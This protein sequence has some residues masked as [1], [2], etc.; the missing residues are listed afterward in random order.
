MWTRLRTWINDRWPV[1]AVVR[2]IREEEI[3]GGSRFAYVFGSVS[4]VLF[5][6]L[7][8][9]GVL[10]IFYYVPTVDHAYDSVMYLRL[11]V[12][13]GWLVHG[14]HYWCAQAFAVVVGLHMARVFLWGAYK[15]PREVTWLTGVL[16]L[17]LVAVM[18]FM[19]PLLAWDQLGF[20][21]A[22][23]GTSIVGTVPW[24]GDFLQ[25][26]VRG[27]E[28][29]GQ[30]TLSRFFVLHVAILPG[31]LLG[32]I[33]LHLV[34]FRQSGSVGPWDPEQRRTTGRFWPDQVYK[35]ILVTSFV[36]VILVGLCAF[37]RAPITGPAD[38]LGRSIEPK[39]VWNFLFLYQ[40][41]KLFKGPW[42]LVGTV[43]LPL[44][45]VLIL[46]LLPFYDRTP[47][48]NPRR[49]PVALAGATVF[50]LVIAVL[51]LLGYWAKPI[52]GGGSPV[53]PVT[54]PNQRGAAP[55][56]KAPPPGVQKGR[57]LFQSQ[58]CGACHRID[59]QSGS[60]GPDLSNEASAGKSAQWLA[61]QIRD[62]KAHNANSTMPSYSSL[63]QEQV[64]EL[65]DYLLTLGSGGA[66]T[67]TESP[68]S[69]EETQT[70]VQGR[71]SKRL[72]T[73][74]AQGPPG[75]AATLIGD[76]RLGKVLFPD[77][78]SSC[79]GPEGVDKVPNPGS[80]R[81]TVPALNPIDPNLVDKEPAAFA[82]RIDRFIQHGS[83]PKGPHPALDMPAYG[84]ERSLT[85]PQIAAV[86]A[87]ILRL[88]GVDRAEI[89]HPGMTP[90]WFFLLT[91]LVFGAVCGV[92]VVLWRAS[93]RAGKPVRQ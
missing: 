77:Y 39:P 35:D 26:F 41:L 63:T 64:K 83:I 25:R 45:L 70:G 13:F 40:A 62:P 47:Q 34:A 84:D 54:E 23:V 60:V 74:G 90:K 20:W 51:T 8:I 89:L 44:V 92:A 18:T 55:S 69:S 1:S 19:G 91:V 57:E 4:L 82:A 81:K 87:Y 22:E 43:G 80:D 30:E 2:W 76:W 73:R 36:V 93:T 33:L 12:P 72:P 53:V 65:V 78:C 6:L 14:L 88:N 7:V 48:K 16:L 49:R 24:I 10:E 46:L 58:G 11:Q 37:W 38:P 9:T 52:T 71:K 67:G 56:Q 79:H 28:T 68:P 59:G 50:V 61:A 21:A 15:S 85:Q 31:L 27:G 42:E 75:E 3:P 66:K 32:V 5:L 29:M 17:L 86:E